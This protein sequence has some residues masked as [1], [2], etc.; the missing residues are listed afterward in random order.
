LLV[1]LQDE[2]DTQ[3]TCQSP[4]FKKMSSF[5][6]HLAKH[7]AL[8]LRVRSHPKFPPGDDLRRIATEFG[9]GWD[10]NR[11][12]K[13]SLGCCQAVACINSSGAVQAL[14]E[15]LP[16]L[17]FGHAIYRHP[18]AVYC[19]NRGGAEIAAVTQELAAGRCT[20]VTERVDAVVRRILNQQW[21]RE[22]IPLRFPKLV[23]DILSRREKPRTKGRVGWLDQARATPTVLS[24]YLYPKFKRAGGNWVTARRE[25]AC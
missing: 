13:E 18:G 16:V 19:L 9:I 24:T 25:D 14:A 23:D 17:C 21:R 2:Q 8:P 10:C 11:S 20:L 22:A 5:L 12:L 4:H 1:L 7:S 6:T 3:I 15:R